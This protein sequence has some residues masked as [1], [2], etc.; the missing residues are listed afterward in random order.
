MNGWDSIFRITRGD[1]ERFHTALKSPETAQREQLRRILAANGT[2]AF[3]IRHGFAG[4][5]DAD[6]YRARVPVQGY[7]DMR[8][9]VGA[10]LEGEPDRVVS[11]PVLLFERTGGSS[12]GPKLIP[13]TR[14]SLDAF[15]RAARPWLHNVIAA[16]PAVRNGRG[17][18]AISPAARLP[19]KSS[20]GIPI[21][22]DNDGAYFGEEIAADLGR[23]SVV[24]LQLAQ[25]EAIEN[26]RYLTLRH[27]LDADDLTLISVWSPTFLKALLTWLPI[28]AEALAK[29]L[30]EGTTTEPDVKAPPGGRFTP[31]PDRA[32]VLEKALSASIPDTRMLWPRLEVISCWTHATSAQFIPD[33]RRAF[34][35]A[36]I[37]GKGLLA[38]EGAVS[39]PLSEYPWPV[40]SLQSGF[41][42]FVD[43]RGCSHLAHELSEGETY[44]LLLTTPGGL[45]RYDIGDMVKMR[46][47]AENTPMLEFMGRAGQTSD[48]CGEKL[49]EAQVRGALPAH[50]GFAMLAPS[51][52]GG[53][54]YRL[55]LDAEEHGVADSNA[56]AFDL[57]L[58][59]GSNPQYRYA[60]R[61]NQLGPV[62]VLRARQPL[63]T[64]LC[65]KAACGSRL[66]DIKPPILYCRTD[67]Q[68][69]Y[70][71]ERIS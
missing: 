25:V 53:P 59:L 21:G 47:R 5:R 67:W 29:D 49:S 35:H 13:Y 68:P 63:L 17:Y 15:R 42:E 10:M 64:Y 44:R 26:W 48:L 62:Q 58:A 60:R 33:L 61:M 19:E 69:V 36:A 32:A 16:H 28:H 6:D 51:L 38:T 3:G 55:L 34:P 14:S 31:R 20:G 4:I 41:Y 46:G 9:E 66:G 30:A 65:W 18:W 50:N 7:E 12:G 52:Q 1:H 54:H 27:L 43:Q 39:I 71:G 11:E 57:D 40:L 22:M 23:L 24:P 8:A 56:L 37:Q 2:S 70:E 45:Y